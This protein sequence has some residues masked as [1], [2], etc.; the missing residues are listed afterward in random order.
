[1]PKTRTLE[2]LRELLFSAAERLEKADGDALEAE[3]KRAKATGE[4]G[5]VLIA[6]GRLELE[7]LR[8]TGRE[9]VPAKFLGSRTAARVEQESNG[10][11]AL[12]A[13]PPAGRRP[14]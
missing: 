8:Q 2:D 14:A 11:R 5:K 12:A 6:T 3:L 13:A 1:M 4:I 9:S 10:P 7:H